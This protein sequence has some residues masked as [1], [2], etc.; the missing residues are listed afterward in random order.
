M[1]SPVEIEQNGL[2]RIYLFAKGAD[3]KVCITREGKL[4]EVKMTHEGI[5]IDVYS[6]SDGEFVGS[7]FSATYDEM[8]FEADVH[9]ALNHVESEATNVKKDT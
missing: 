1:S 7:P 6:E 3:N 4:F 2:R 5:I 8:A 9:A